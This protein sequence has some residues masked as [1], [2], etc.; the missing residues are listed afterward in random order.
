M[1]GHKPSTGHKQLAYGRC[2]YSIV[3]HTHAPAATDA[4]MLL[5]YNLFYSEQERRP[6]LAVLDV[7]KRGQRPAYDVVRHLVHPGREHRHLPGSARTDL[8]PPPRK[9]TNH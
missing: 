9:A 5:L 7:V 1:Q 4:V 6:G 2:P 8:A 3:D